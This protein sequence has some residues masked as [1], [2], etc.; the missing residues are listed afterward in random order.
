ML[1]AV[2][3]LL[4][5]TTL[6]KLQQVPSHTWWTI[7]LAIVGFIV[8]VVLIRFAAQMSKLLL[9]GIVLFLLFLLCTQWV[10]E[11]DEPAWATPIIEPL[12]QFLPSKGKPKPATQ[13]SALPR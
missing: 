3:S 2:M 8:V 13:P 1:S 5:T 7:A 11:R 6:E 10:Y 9:G 12:A 4:A